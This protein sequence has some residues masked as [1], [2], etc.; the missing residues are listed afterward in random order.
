MPRFRRAA[1][2]SGTSTSFG[3]VNFP[4]RSIR[5]FNNQ[6]FIASNGGANAFDATANWAADTTWAVSQPWAP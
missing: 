2:D 1:L 6:L 5:H 3:S 4:D